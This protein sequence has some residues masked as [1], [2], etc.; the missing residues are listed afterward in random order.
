MRHGG[1]SITNSARET[2][3]LTLFTILIYFPK[4]RYSS[5]K[6]QYMAKITT[7]KYLKKEVRRKKNIVLVGGTFDI[8]HLDHIKFLEKSKRLGK[9]LIVCITSD[10]N[11]RHRK[12]NHRPIFT[13]SERAKVVSAIRAVDYVFISNTSAYDDKIISVL[14]PDI[15]VFSFDGGKKL[16]R[17]KYKVKIEKSYPDTEVKFVDTGTFSTTKII[18]HLSKTY[19]DN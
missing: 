12:G 13:Q 14:R 16:Y 19:R 15:L 4:H 1:L 9:T 11:V 8:L 5:E 7:L 10:K 6:R 18:E 3:L 2:S 17:K